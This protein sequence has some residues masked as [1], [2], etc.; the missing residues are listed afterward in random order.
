MSIHNYE[1][2]WCITTCVNRWT[3]VVAVTT[4]SDRGDSIAQLTEKIRRFEAGGRVDFSTERTDE[5]GDLYDAVASLARRVSS[6]HET[7]E[8]YR[9]RLFELTTASDIDPD[10]KLDRLLEL[11]CERLG[12]EAAHIIE[13]DEDTDTFDVVRAAGP[14][15]LEDTV[16]TNLAE[17]LCRQ[18]IESESIVTV[19]HPAERGDDQDTAADAIGSYIG[20]RLVV[21]GTCFG[22]VCFADRDPRSETFSSAE[23]TFVELIARWISHHYERVAYEQELYQYERRFRA[24]FEDPKM[25][26]GLLEPDGTVRQANR[27]GLDRI[28]ADLDAVVGKPFWKTP[29]WTHSE[30]LQ[31]D[32]QTWVERAAAGEYVEYEAEHVDKDGD[33]YWVSGTIR[34]VTDDDGDVVSLVVSARDVTERK[35]RE[36]QLS[37]L[38]E[39]VPGMVY[40]CA[41]EPD[42]PF[43]F[44]SEGCREVTGYSSEELVSGSVNWGDDVIVEGNDDLWDEVQRAIDARER[45]QVTYQIE[46]DG[47]DRR[48]VWEQGRGVFDAD[49]TLQGLEGVIQDITEQ[50]E[51]EA[52]L[53]RTRT[54]LEQSQRLA[55]V[56]AWEF[57]AT[58]DDSVVVTMTDEVYR[59]LDIPIDRTVRLREA[60]EFYH[61]DDRDTVTDAL[62]S[63]TDEKQPFAF[64]CRLD[65]DGDC[66]QWIQSIGR[67]VIEDGEVRAIRGSVQDI[68]ERKERELVLEALHETARD[69]LS[70]DSV[71]ATATLMVETATEILDANCVAIYQLDDEDAKL[72]AT[73]SSEQFTEW[74]DG[75][76]A[77]GANGD[78]PLWS[79]FITNEPVVVDDTTPVDGATVLDEQVS[80]GLFL[81]IGGHGVFA[82]VTTDPPLGA[83]TR[84][85][86][87]TLVAQTAAAFDRLQSEANLRE[88]ES[89]LESQNRQLQRQIQITDIIRNIDTS[90]IEATTRQEVERVV[91]DRLVEAADI[92]FAWVG[93]FDATETQLQPRVWAGSGE[94][95]LDETAFSA[96]TAETEPAVV[97]ATNEQ[98]A[99]VTNIVDYLQ[100]EGWVR[101]ALRNEFYSALAVPLLYDGYLYGVLAVYADE[102]DA[103]TDLERTVFAELGRNVGH[104]INA[105]E[106]QRALHA[107]KLTQLTVTIAD[108]DTPLARL[109]AA[110]ESD[111]SFTGLATKGDDITRLFLTVDSDDADTIASLLSESLT[112]SDYRHISTGESESVF[113]IDVSE[114]P[115]A[116]A[117][118]QHGGKPVSLLAG[119][120]DLRLVVNVP[121]TTNVREFLEMLAEK[122]GDVELASRRDIDHPVQSG[123][124]LVSAMLEDLTD[125]QLEVLRT[126]YFAGFFEWPRKSTG[127]EV[128]SMLGVTQPTINR[129]LRLGMQ[130]LLAQLFDSERLVVEDQSGLSDDE[131]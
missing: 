129:H 89:Q 42:W 9:T 80:G 85:L 1:T 131:D 64:E 73:A 67:P 123:P 76:P 58:G 37:T 46:T 102:A 101:T 18:T 43:R 36:R 48:W 69:L 75:D 33:R 23:E 38:M 66:A 68:T 112:V 109:S 79:S 83:Q 56:G 117:L 124:D 100:G 103:F 50:K 62:K 45:F 99:V 118:V 7:S 87:E 53:E 29:W 16:D 17:K 60:I 28:D 57:D 77:I 93:G 12:L 88:R 113:E 30:S 49:G 47:G 119:D 94:R 108:A 82:V 59:I 14:T 2:H 35:E 127:E 115:V 65:R 21:S 95:Y 71:E 116:T 4:R 70:V 98:P 27:A 97:A 92:S 107:D 90:L 128:A 20:S 11:G 3:G 96:E 51:R 74:C 125:R 52:E 40:R 6:D 41:N 5:V 10:E 130:R 15:L 39:N 61:P 110:V 86:A 104:T 8:R 84:Q 55:E 44:V 114:D 31:A 106:T 91:C 26:V 22:T 54:M 122:Y 63:A 81:P 32:L 72:R 78:S 105:V 126:A 24:V 111:I 13:R 120:G 121:T 19:S 34:P 25:H